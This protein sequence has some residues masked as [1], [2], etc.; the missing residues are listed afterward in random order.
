MLTLV[1]K[2]ICRYFR[3]RQLWCLARTK[4]F[5]RLAVL[6][7]IAD[8]AVGDHLFDPGVHSWPK[9]G[10]F[11]SLLALYN[12]HVRAM[13]L[14]EHFRSLG[15]RYDDP[16][17]LE[18]DSIMNGQLISVVP[19]LSCSGLHLCFGVGPPFQYYCEKD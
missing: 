6:V 9:Y 7:F 8:W 17:P 13:D 16:H 12:A 11:G 18:Y 10:L 4:C 15:W 5:F 2:E 14:S 1:L 3:P 19:V